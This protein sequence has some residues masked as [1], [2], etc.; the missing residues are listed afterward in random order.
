M[1]AQMDKY[2]MRYSKRRGMYDMDWPSLPPD[3]KP[4]EK[5]KE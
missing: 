4:K 3:F 5:K 2:T 1:V